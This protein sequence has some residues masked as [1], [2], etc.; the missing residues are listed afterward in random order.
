MKHL[1]SVAFVLAVAAHSSAQISV[2]PN[3]YTRVQTSYSTQGV[4]NEM[5]NTSTTFSLYPTVIILVGSNM[6]IA[7]FAGIEVGSSRSYRNN[8]LQNEQSYFGIAGGCGLYFR[9][10]DQGVLRFSIGPKVSFGMSFPADS[11]EFSLSPAIGAPA[12]I[13]LCFND[14][15]FV[16][17]SPTLAELSYTHRSINENQSNGD[18]RFVLLTQAG[19]SI[20]F[21]IT[22]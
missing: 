3:F 6:E 12:N 22:F 10:I 5:R 19:M 14:H 21:F 1:F 9:L 7:P 20:G 17:A 8:E 13:D 16:R 18:L 4:N 2:G 11:D 15:F